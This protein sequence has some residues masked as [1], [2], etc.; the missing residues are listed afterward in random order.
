MTNCKPVKTPM[1]SIQMRAADD[2][3]QSDQKDIDG[4]RR[5]VGSLQWCSIMTRFDISYA[6]GICSRYVTNPTSTYDAALKRIVAYLASTPMEGDRYG[7][8][9]GSEGLLVGYTDALWRDCLDTRRS[10]LGYIFS[11][12]NGPIS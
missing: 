3:Y 1:A 5:I 4:Y 9:E 2:G 11:L 8:V 7:L 12:Y 10:T 6:L